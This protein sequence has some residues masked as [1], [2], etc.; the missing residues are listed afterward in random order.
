MER[1]PTASST[2][3][4]TWDTPPISNLATA[5]RSQVPFEAD[6]RIERTARER[7]LALVSVSP[8]THTIVLTG[9]LN[10]RSAYTLEVE[11]ERL[12]EEGVTGLTLDLRELTRIDPVGV[13]V[14][15]FRR[16]LCERRGYDFAVIPGSESIRRVFAQAGVDDS[17]PSDQDP[18]TVVRR[19]ALALAHRSRDEC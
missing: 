17:P 9:E 10:H 7:S 14:I 12:C 4:G 13:A 5:D 2:G 15:A 6:S 16:G 18:V 11:I 1:Q 3:I 8:W 19:G